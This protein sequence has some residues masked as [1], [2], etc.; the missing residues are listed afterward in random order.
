MRL[1]AVNISLIE[2]IL[3]VSKCR[4]FLDASYSLNY[5]PAVI[6]KHI[7]KAEEEL[8]VKLFNRG[9]KSSSISMTPECMLII[10]DL[11]AMY[12]HYHRALNTL[13][14]LKDP[15]YDNVVRL[16]VTSKTWHCGESE[17]IA[18]FIIHNP[19]IS[20]EQHRAYAIDQLRKLELAEIDGAFIICQG[21]IE[22]YEALRD[23]RGKKYFNFF[24]IESINQMYMA[25]DENCKLAKLDETDFSSFRDYYIAFNSDRSAKTCV[26]NE[27]PFQELC[28]KY[29]FPLKSLSLSTADSSAFLL[30]QHIKL[31]I[32]VPNPEMQ[33][34][35]IKYIRLRDWNA[36]MSSYF[37]TCN[38]QCSKATTK[39]KKAVTVYSLRKKA[40]TF[41]AEQ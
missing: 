33:F 18:D 13:D 2:T 10:D 31:A 11:E 34:E 40:E 22:D 41:A 17:I 29:Q 3:E 28:R 12:N 21:K 27:L 15:A 37:V 6:S 39:F 4:S 5:T 30:A 7:A 24:L 36:P 16:G 9:S 23:Y 1:N 8:G 35:G 32:P 25:V 14:A 38:R 20:V 19:D 26:R